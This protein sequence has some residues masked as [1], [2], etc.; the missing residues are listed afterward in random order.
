MSD[1][2]PS[3]PSPEPEA[4]SPRPAT[5]HDTTPSSL[6]APRDA[7]QPSS[8]PSASI[9]SKSPQKSDDRE[10]SKSSKDDTTSGGKYTVKRSPSPSHPG[11][12]RPNSPHSPSHSPP[13]S[14]LT[15]DGFSIRISKPQW[16]ADAERLSASYPNAAHDFFF[17]TPNNPLCVYK[18]GDPWPTNTGQDSLRIIREIRPVAHD[19][20]IR[21]KWSDDIV[22]KVCDLL[23]ERNVQWTSVDPVAFAEVGKETFCPFLIWIGVKPTSLSYEDA[24]TAAE[25]VTSF[26]TGSGLD[27]IEI[28]FRESIVTRLSGPKLTSYFSDSAGG[29]GTDL[30]KLASCKPLTAILGLSISVPKESNDRHYGGTGALYLLESKEKDDMYLLTCSHVVRKKSDDQK[31][32]HEVQK[33]VF[34]P[35]RKVYKEVIKSVREKIL[36]GSCHLDAVQSNT[37]PENLTEMVNDLF[38]CKWQSERHVIGKVAYAPPVNAD[39]D[40]WN[41]DWAL[42]KLDNNKFD[43]TTFKGN[44][45]F[46]DKG[47]SDYTKLMYPNDNDQESLVCPEEGLLPAAKVVSK[48]EISNPQHLDMHGEK[49]WFVLKNGIR[50]GTTYGTSSGMVS[51]IQRSRDGESVRSKSIAVSSSNN[52][53][54]ARAFADKGDS[55]SIILTRDGGI[56][57]LLTSKSRNGPGKPVLTYFTPFWFI[58][59]RIRKVYPNC[60]LYEAA[61]PVLSS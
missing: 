41:E 19:H 34:A 46:V 53:L 45:I 36:E 59:E 24:R 61:I 39:N 54:T 38:A 57:G 8:S 1:K 37:D 35:S 47:P 33:K 32:A 25:A 2:P 51:V 5:S 7:K 17:G 6:S 50:T 21:S 18:S 29:G 23:D 44:Q 28:G 48:E 58:M 56:L 30:A 12:S 52:G 13:H 10:D 9:T 40:H 16:L 26:L 31:F 49:C 14:S 4:P 27:A 15:L 22:M 43:L 3:T 11:H 55:G 20:P 42:I 60:C